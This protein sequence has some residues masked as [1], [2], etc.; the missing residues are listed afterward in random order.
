MV[1]WNGNGIR[2]SA[3]LNQA[4]AFANTL[5]NAGRAG[6]FPVNDYFLALMMVGMEGMENTVGCFFEAMADGVVVTVVV[7]VTHF[8][9]G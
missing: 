6:L 4:D 5:S 3:T 1:T 8:G 7:V 2:S 9:F